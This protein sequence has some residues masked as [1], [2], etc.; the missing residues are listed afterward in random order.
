MDTF[1]NK[2]QPIPDD[3]FKQTLPMA[4]FKSWYNEAIEHDAI[5][6]PDAFCLSTIGVDEMPE[7][8]IL[9][10]KTLDETTG[11]TFFS[12]SMSPKGQA[13]IKNPKASMTFFW[14]QLGK[15]VRIQ[16]A[17]KRATKDESD[18]YFRKRVRGSQ[19]G[20]W[21]SEQSETLE[22]REKMISQFKLLES[23]FEGREIPR[24]DNWVGYHLDPV[25]YEF[26]LN[27]EYRLHDR[28]Q[29]LR[30]GDSQW[31]CRRVYP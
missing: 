28:F 3:F 1:I 22:S 10:L 12:N 15:Q 29:Y 21:V 19:I 27:G 6:K 8:R 25:K 11:Y 23:E 26:W 7:G 24:P 14:D 5:D 9:L 30:V 20:A 31:D 4:L 17:V 16:G 18:A 13:L 2:S